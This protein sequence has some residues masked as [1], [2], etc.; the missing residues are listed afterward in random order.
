MGK[1]GRCCEGSCIAEWML[2]F[3]LVIGFFSQILVLVVGDRVEVTMPFAVM[4][5]V[6][7][8]LL[9]SFRGVKRSLAMAGLVALPLFVYSTLSLLWTS[10]ASYSIEKLFSFWFCYFI[11]FYSL[12]MNVERV[13]RVLGALL[14]AITVLV[15]A[16]TIYL[17]ESSASFY[18][19][20][21]V[22]RSVYLSSGY[23]GGAGLVL[24]SW[25]RLPIR[26]SVFIALSCLLL[27]CVIMSG[28]RG[29]LVFSVILYV[30]GCICGGRFKLML[31]GLAASAVGLG[32]L[33][34]L[35]AGGATFLLDRSVGRIEALVA[36][37]GVESRSVFFSAL[38][39]WAQHPVQGIF[40]F[41]IGSFGVEFDGIDGRAYPH[42]IVIELLMELG[43]FGFCLF[44]LPYL[45]WLLVGKSFLW[46]K[47]NGVLV[48]L[49]V[50]EMSNLL[51]SFTYA[52]A[53]TLYFALGLGLL[54]A[55]R[56]NSL[57]RQYAPSGRD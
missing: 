14:W 21:E 57:C 46:S 30:V 20:S 16:A 6:S 11:L 28:A 55:L 41:G 31:L 36:A 49:V 51:K 3:S 23:Y 35:G 42:N 8:L 18:S 44:L 15:V 39:F 17:A 13:Q 7:T 50:Y 2:V 33:M 52:D 5:F 45:Y 9:V 37:G 43:L 56:R 26:S 22:A 4:F 12:Q 53:R 24:L 47:G 29:P 38:A 48:A 10:S 32:V 1:L 54:V 25:L 40:G 34:L 27:V 19:L